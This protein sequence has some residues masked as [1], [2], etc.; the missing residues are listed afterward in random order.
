M[1]SCKIVQKIC[2]KFLTTTQRFFRQHNTDS[3]WKYINIHS[4][5]FL[6]DS[7]SLTE[8]TVPLNTRKNAWTFYKNFFFV[9]YFN[10][11]L[12]KMFT[13]LYLVW[14]YYCHFWLFF[15]NKLIHPPMSCIILQ[16]WTCRSS[17]Q[18]TRCVG[19]CCLYA[20]IFVVLHLSFSI[21][22]ERWREKA[23]ETQ[24]REQS[25]WIFSGLNL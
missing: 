14:F 18:R 21:M 20:V 11:Y 2:G 17:S 12:E 22:N 5:Y 23:R 1:N 4:K 6:Y 13:F 25:R 10:N 19:K 3:S 15:Y 16:T 7:E 9:D 24:Q 8:G